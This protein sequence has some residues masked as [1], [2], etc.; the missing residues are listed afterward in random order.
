[1]IIDAI[2]LLKA[3]INEAGFIPV[4]GPIRFL[5]KF[6]DLFASDDVAVRGSW[7][8]SPGLII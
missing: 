1:M 3:L 6:I 7:T 8:K 4:D 2:T 5:L